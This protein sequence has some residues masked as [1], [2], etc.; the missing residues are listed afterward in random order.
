M[1]FLEFLKEQQPDVTTIQ[2]AT[3]YYIAEKHG[4]PPPKMRK[5]MAAPQDKLDAAQHQL[6]QH[7][8]ALE[9]ACLATLSMGWDDDET[10]IRNAFAEAKTKLPVIELAIVAVVAMYGMYLAVTGGVKKK[11]V[12]RTPDG[13]LKETIEYHAPQGP[14]GTVVNL[15]KGGGGGT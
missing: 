14:L 7:P 15:F 12:Q 11:V 2:Q 10:L 4:L 9:N 5:A 1:T 6:E 8:R 13:S 3:R